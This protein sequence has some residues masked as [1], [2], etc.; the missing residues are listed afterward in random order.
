METLQPSG[1]FKNRGIGNL[2]SHYFEEGTRGFVCS[3]GGNAGIA[4][5]YSGRMLKVPVKVIV[6]QTTLPLMHQ[7]IREE[8]AEVTVHGALWD[9][10][11]ALARQI[12]QEQG[13]SYI[14]P[15]DNPYIW[16]GNSTIIDEIEETDVSPDAILVAVGGGGLLC[17]LVE[18][19]KRHKKNEVAVLAVETEG[20]ASFNAAVKAGKVV[21]LEKIDTVATSLGAKKVTSQALEYTKSH[22]ISSYVVSDK[23]AVEACLAFADDHYTLVEPACGTALAPIYSGMD[24][25]SSYSTIVVIVCGGKGVSLSL[26]RSWAERFGIFRS[27]T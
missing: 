26:L 11:D 23:Q 19:L 2:C 1:S 3:S 14:P 25:F 6:P 8:G 5:A 9:E 20:A 7:K 4:A 21:T 24:I 10:A 22:P 17:G 16:L 15:F 27:P 13:Y 18:G 12:A